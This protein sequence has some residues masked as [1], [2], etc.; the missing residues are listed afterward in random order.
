MR[1]SILR[2]FLFG[3]VAVSV[4]AL[5]PGQATDPDVSVLANEPGARLSLKETSSVFS[6]E[7]RANTGKPVSAT[8]A[9]KILAPDDKVLAEAS[10]PVWVSSTYQRAELPLKWVPE[11]GLGHVLGARLFYEIRL[12]SSARSAASGI[13]SPYALVPEIFELHFMGLNFIGLGRRYVARVWATRPDSDQPVA[14]VS[15][16][17]FFG[18]PVDADG[19]KGWKARAST[20]AR[21]EARITLQLPELS[22]AP[23]EEESD[24][25][26][27]GTNGNFKTFLT[28]TLHVW[29]Q[30]AVLLATDKPLYQPDQTLHMRALLL[31]DRRHAWGQQP[32][33]FTV[34]DPDDTIVFSADAQTSRFGIAA[35]DWTIPSLQKLGNYR[36]A[37][38]VAGE[39]GSR[40]V[41]AR[42]IVRISHYELPTFTVNVTPDRPFYLPGQNADLKIRANYLFGKPVL[43]GHVRILREASREWNY[44]DQK[45]ETEEEENREGELNSE[46]EFQIALDLSKSHAALQDTDWKRFQDIRYAAF[47][48]DNSTRRSEER[49]FDIRVSREAIHLY[50]LNAAAGMPVGLRPAFYISTSQ[51]DGTP[52]AVDVR[53]RLYT[54]DPSDPEA[55]NPVVEPFATASVQTNRYG[56]ACVRF[57]E[58][59][60]REQNG[61]ETRSSDRI[62]VALDAKAPQGG[63]GHHLESYSL[64]EEP[65]LRITPEK[66]ILKPG[67]AIDAEIESSISRVRIG[68]DLIQADTQTVLASQEVKLA[69]A[70]ARV[71]FPAVP[72]FSGR[73]LL[74]AYPLHAESESYSLYSPMAGS[75][76]LVPKPDALQLEMKPA[77]ATYRPGESATVN[78]KVS[79]QNGVSSE[80]ALGLLVYDQA[81]EELARNE[82]SLFTNGYEHLDPNLGFRPLEE[83]G[84]SIAGVSLKQ[85]LDRQTNDAVPKDLELVAEAMLFYQGGAPLLMESSDPPRDL[86]RVFQKQISGVLGP[87]ARLLEESFSTIGHFPANAADYARL[88]GEKGIDPSSLTDPWGRPYHLRRLFRWTNEVLEFRSEGP[89]KTAGT[90]DDFTALS[91]SRPFFER[92]AQ[93]LRAVMEAYHKRTGG[94]IRDQATLESACDEEKVALASFADPWGTPY[95][96]AFEANREKY[97]LKVLSAGPD[98]RFR[99]ATD[100]SSGDVDDL[101]VSV[102]GMPYF[103]ETAEHIS[104]ALLKSAKSSAHFPETEQEFR[105]AMA[106]HGLDWDALRDPWGRPYHVTLTTEAA[107]SDA[108]TLHAYGEK[109][110]TSRKPVTR[111]SRMINIASDGPDG[112]PNTPDDFVLAKFG[113]PFLEETGGGTPET[114]TPQEPQ[115]I[116][117]GN[118]GAVRLLVQDPTGAAIP[119]AKITLTNEATGVRYDGVSNDQGAFLLY[120]LPPGTYRLLVES[121]AFRPYVLT[122][123]PVVS[124]NAT[125]VEVRLQFGTTS[126]TVEVAAESIKL[127]TSTALF[128]VWPHKSLATESGSAS[129]QIKLALST[130]RLREYFPET[131]FWQP[132]IHVGGAGHASVKVPLADNITTWK[133]SAIASTLDGQVATAS[134]ELRSFMPLFVE[135]EPP[136]VLT[137]GDEL[138]LPVTVRNYLDKAQ[139]ISLDWAAEPWAELLSASAVRLVVPAGDYAG[140]TF[141]FRA[142]HPAKAAKQRLTV[143]N[144]SR[145]SAGD[146]AEKKLLVHADG[147]RRLAQASSIFAGDTSLSLEIPSEA[148]PGA[149]EA[150]LVLYPNLITHVSDAIEGIMGR[151]YGCAEQTISS[152]Y[153]SLLWLQLQ[154]DGQLPPS[155]V[156]ARARGYLRLAYAKLLR[157]REPDGGFSLWGH[158][159]S[160]TAV[161]AYALR[162]LT[163][164]SEFTEVDAGVVAAA[165]H[166]LLAQAAPQG[167]WTENGRSSEGSTLDLTAYVVEV[168][169]RDLYRRRSDDQ[170]L[171]AERQAVRNGIAYFAQHS[172]DDSSPYGLALIAL[173]KL[174]ARDDASQEIADLLALAQAEGQASYWDLQHNTIFYGWGYTG[175]IET[176]ALVLEAFALSEKLGNP[177][178]ALTRALQRGTLFLLKNKDAYGVWYSTQAT[179]DV[180]ETLVRRLETT[181]P[182]SAR[183]RISIYVDGKPGPE[184]SAPSN[185]RQLTPQRADLTPFLPPGKHTVELRGGSSASS[186]VYVNASYYLPWTDPAVTG[187]SVGRSTAE[188]LRYSIQFDRANASPG[189]V[190]HCT[191]HAERIGFRGYG[192]MLAEVGLPPGA[193]VDRASLD[194]AVSTASWDLQ[195]YEIQPDRVVF[196]LWP[197]AGGTTFSFAFKPRFRMSAQSSESVLYDYYNP[198]A[199]TSV[200]PT[201]FTVR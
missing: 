162:F 163:E 63:Q 55:S 192:M 132:E 36:A 79:E 159:A 85:L 44:R 40:Q 141:S 6:I 82:A 51:A 22:G 173:A 148:L 72:Q 43:H 74:A 20:N 125:D 130:P 34:R 2:V 98:K 87:V 49:H 182:E 134:T 21:G 168:L 108:V 140:Q 80:S 58:P 47:V 31:D 64:E 17:A 67:E 193:D 66:A 37:A 201:R 139:D 45:W 133:I 23:D 100:D 11:S 117:T 146:A 151:P 92:D 90:S 157:Y 129:G 111:S 153:P 103:R 76:V 112:Q 104:A 138:E 147:Q 118:S 24:L 126:E 183:A 188:S 19:P 177:S 194:S 89:D 181:G 39:S 46:G 158:S 29:R 180:L 121:F 48:T 3:L 113:S 78:L 195:S 53:V 27:H 14:G 143:F 54:Q 178:P 96:F 75:S 77:K 59:L 123:I 65:A 167:G 33:R 69:H 131:L 142:A 114:L 50:V 60:R 91:L 144:R 35:T 196:Y 185:A 102:E 25:E 105:K 7:L 155:P 15:L 12:T 9:A 164:A 32:V 109:V 127:S 61:E 8:L 116:Y 10:A 128:A 97:L 70:S 115:P 154:K 62:Y 187:P 197:R 30:A 81:V 4:P 170:D 71:F 152:A 136:K 99:G 26:I 150:E 160:A 18:D 56:I 124:S 38:E 57:P 135:L 42:Q 169:A 172:R 41:S 156:D 171:A 73:L 189:D 16:A 1:T 199:R 107:Y 179:V 166:W 52:A 101:V 186:S 184:L 122:N 191:V 175:R 198:L 137:V 95:R 5:A 84:D 200:S 93:R 86:D 13:L 88:L 83:D 149:S 94:Y 145:A 106:E 119:N 120:D 161:S 165:R 174:A 190:I 68:V 176:T 110:S 28:A